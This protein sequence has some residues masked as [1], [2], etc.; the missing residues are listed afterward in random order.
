MAHEDWCGKPCSEC[1]E[2]C[3]LDQEIPCS[4]NCDLLQPDGSRYPR[5]CKETGCD[6]YL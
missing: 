4:P 3:L 1:V 2:P 5:L 6:A